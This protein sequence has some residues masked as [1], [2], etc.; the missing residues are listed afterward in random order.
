M[1]LK[2]YGC[3]LEVKALDEAGAFSGYAS[4]FGNVDSYHDVIA[5]GA[6][7]STLVKSASTG[8]M[9]A[10]LWQHDSAEPIGVITAL[11]EDARGLYMEAK[12]AL[13]V[14]RG[15]EA[16]ELLKIGALN[17]LSIGFSTVRDEWDDKKRIRRLLEADLWEVSMVT[18]PANDAARIENVKEQPA[19]V[20]EMESRLRDAGL[21]HRDAKAVAPV[22]FKELGLRDEGEAL[23]SA[24]TKLTSILKG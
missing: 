17:G 3:P 2:R 11:S 21:S 20:R 23:V 7:A 10:L 22:V 24:I 14:T 4:V 15:R 16:Y 1:E 8:R 6:F 13:S 18:F 12:L 19:T 5:P 9:P